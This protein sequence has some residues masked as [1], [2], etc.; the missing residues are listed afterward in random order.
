[1]KPTDKRLIFP[2]PEPSIEWEVIAPKKN[3][4]DWTNAAQPVTVT[5]MKHRNNTLYLEIRIAKQVLDKLA[6]APDTTVKVSRSIK[7]NALKLEPEVSEMARRLIKL[8]NSGRVVIKAAFQVGGE[9]LASQNVP[10]VINDGVLI[11]ANVKFPYRPGE[12]M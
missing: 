10:A 1:M 3:K 2:L 5:F 7:S 11:L 4:Q 12:E 8:G 6:W 9:P